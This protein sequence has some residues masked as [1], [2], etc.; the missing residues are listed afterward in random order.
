MKP[1]MDFCMQ[2]KPTNHPHKKH[3]TSWLYH[4]KK[5]CFF[6]SFNVGL[7]EY[8]FKA[9]LV[10]YHRHCKFFCILATLPKSI[11]MDCKSIAKIWRKCKVGHVK[12]GNTQLKHLHTYQ[13]LDLKHQLYAV[14]KSLSN[15]ALTKWNYIS[16]T[17]S[18]T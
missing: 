13:S 17:A 6:D 5:A 3:T 15:S 7:F 12:T 11:M 2:P 9:S 1:C 4:P 18:T 14:H 10:T 16:N 8:E